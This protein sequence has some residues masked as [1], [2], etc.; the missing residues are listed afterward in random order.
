MTVRYAEW[1]PGRVVA[2]SA[3]LGAA[4]GALIGFVVILVPTVVAGIAGGGLSV[5]A[6]LVLG[7]FCAAG[8]GAVVGM[9]CGLVA[10]V[11]L[12]L[13]AGSARTRDQAGRPRL[14][15]N[16][17][18]ASLTGGIGAVLLPGALL[19]TAEVL[20]AYGWAFICFFVGAAA[21]AAGAALGPYV[22]YGKRGQS[23]RGAG[24]PAPGGRARPVAPAQRT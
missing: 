22:L 6:V 17:W 20:G 21:F 12:L 10:S 15:I 2:R 23:R 24:R 1:R 9:A 13:A 11:P 7:G 19:V 18:R 4:Y 8:I 3:G 16:R 14:P 5:L